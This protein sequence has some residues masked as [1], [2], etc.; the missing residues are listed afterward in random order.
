MLP[1]LVFRFL[2]IRMSIFLTH[3]SSLSYAC[4][5][6]QKNFH[7]RLVSWVCFTLRAGSLSF[8]YRAIPMKWSTA[9][10]FSPTCFPNTFTRI[11]PLPLTSRSYFFDWL[12]LSVLSFSSPG[13]IDTTSPPCSALITLYENCLCDYSKSKRIQIY[14]VILF[15]GMKQETLSLALCSKIFFF[16]FGG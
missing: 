3:T 14:S 7:A 1:C 11:L 12:S 4:L 9:P 8:Y 5:A 16:F 13:L 15:M 10:D 2:S 6:P